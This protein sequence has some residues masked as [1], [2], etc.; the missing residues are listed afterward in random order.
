MLG[1]S[2]TRGLIVAGILC[3]SACAAKTVTPVRISQQGDGEL[4]CSDLHQQIAENRLEAEKYF[5]KDKQVEDQNVAKNVAGA[6]PVVGL[7]T[8]ASTDLSNEE[9]VKAR[10]L[11]DR[12]EHLAYLAKQKGCTE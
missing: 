11:V 7:F 2:L 9:Q 5:R 3:L 6:I 8:V 10:A 4:S 1:K 12:G